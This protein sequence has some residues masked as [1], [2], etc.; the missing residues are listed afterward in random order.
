MLD[1]YNSLVKVYRQVKQRLSTRHAAPLRLKL[2]KRRESDA[3]VYNLPT[4]SEIAALVVGDFDM[5]NAERDIVVE[6][7]NGKLQRIDE[8]H[9][10]YFPLQYPLLFP[11]GEDGYREDTQYR[12]GSVRN[13]R[14]RK[15][16]TLKQ[17]FS[18]RFQ[19]RTREAQTI[20]RGGRLFQQIVCDAFAAIEFERLKF[21]KSHQKEL[22]AEKYRGLSAASINGDVTPASIGKKI[23]IPSTFTGGMRYDRENFQDAMTI[24]AFKGFPQLF[25]T[26]TCNP[27]W[28]ELINFFEKEN[29]SAEDRPD[30]LARMFKI[31][32]NNLIK[33]ITKGSMFGKSTAGIRFGH[34][35]IYYY[36]L[37]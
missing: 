15:R 26:F 24:C 7:Q 12:E 28:P 11:Y 27:K 8:L 22:R 6:E 33:D 3:R 36:M 37:I 21:I 35:Y 16:L 25:I 34:N 32:L 13:S 30:I 29:C 14:V 31:K 10:A 19:Q 2:I 17:Y 18:Y 20:I 4:A 5:A 9:P 23:I 1:R